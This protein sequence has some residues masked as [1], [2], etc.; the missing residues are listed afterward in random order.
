MKQAKP[1]PPSQT[2]V[3]AKL[4]GDQMT[5][6]ETRQS[7]EATLAQIKAELEADQ[8]ASFAKQRAVLIQNSTGLA[9]PRLPEEET[10][11]MRFRSH[12][13]SVDLIRAELA[14]QDALNPPRPVM[15][16]GGDAA[17][18]EMLKQEMARTKKRIVLPTG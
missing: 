8:I 14:E 13:A 4:P 3:P 15:P 2:A 12:V 1:L 18:V 16:Q 9:K 6:E 11:E 10:P 17:T 5:Q 7:Q